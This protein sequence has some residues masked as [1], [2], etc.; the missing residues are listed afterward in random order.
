MLFWA[1]QMC[2][3]SW[4]WEL[5]G[6]R[7]QGKASSGLTLT[8]ALNCC[9]FAIFWSHSFSSQELPKSEE[10]DLE[11]VNLRLREEQEKALLICDT[12]LKAY[13]HP[14]PRVNLAFCSVIYLLDAFHGTQKFSGQ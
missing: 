13:F 11:F 5:A 6:A 14:P 1:P 12:S 3:Q 10:R 2:S 9:F 4:R 8:W 7:L